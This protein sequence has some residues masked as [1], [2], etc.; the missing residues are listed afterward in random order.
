MDEITL[1]TGMHAA[2]KSGEETVESMFGGQTK[3]VG[4]K[5]STSQKMNDFAKGEN[6]Q[7]KTKEQ[8]G[9]DGGKR[10]KRNSP[11][12]NRPAS[13][14]RKSL[15]TR[16]PKS[17]HRRP[18]TS[19]S[20]AIRDTTHSTTACHGK[21]ARANSTLGAARRSATLG[22]KATTPRPRK[23]RR[24]AIDQRTHPLRKAYG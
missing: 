18:T 5:R 3:A 20:L 22:L 10:P 17:F 12:R 9:S 23:K 14:K 4:D 15:P 8:A 1:L 11:P 7:E 21:R 24:H 13:L 6:G 2:L 16:T 19:K